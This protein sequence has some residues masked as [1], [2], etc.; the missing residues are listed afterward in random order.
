MSFTNYIKIF[1]VVLRVKRL[2]NVTFKNGVASGVYFNTII[3]L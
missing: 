3:A 2:Y 1:S